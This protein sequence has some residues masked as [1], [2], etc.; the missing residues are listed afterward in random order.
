MNTTWTVYGLAAALAAIAVVPS[1]AAGTAG[2]QFLKI[3][4]SA[5]AVAMGETTGATSTDV[6][7]T[8][9][10]PAG[11]ADLQDLQFTAS[12]NDGLVDTQHQFFAVARP[13]GENAF[14][15][16]VTRMD[17]GEIERYSAADAHEGSFDAGSLAAGVTMARKLGEDLSLGATVKM[18][19]EK[20]DGESASTFA[21]DLGV[22]YK[23]NGWNL[24]AALQNVGPAMKFVE[25]DTDL[26][27]TARV[28]ASRKLLN[29]KMTLALEAALPRDNDA[30]ISGGA[31]YLVNP[32][33]A[34][35]GGYIATP[36]NQADLGGLVGVTGGVGLN[37]G[38][39]A[40]DYGVRPFGDLGMSHRI[41]FSARFAAL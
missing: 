6:T 1:S 20:I 38:R 12:H 8:A 24:G 29:E 39:F 3:A 5:R 19:Q 32:L 36:G 28:S 27:T 23:T 17:F 41:S 9:G 18:V 4:A 10:N 16:S 14:G 30:T 35:R 22:V 15:L 31:E 13:F 26:P 34:L 37:L 21:G 33:L 25:E 11:L 2:A 40:L 7:A